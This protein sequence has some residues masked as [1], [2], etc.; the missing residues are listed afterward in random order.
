MARQGGGRP[1]RR[2]GRT[3][4]ALERRAGSTSSHSTPPRIRV[5]RKPGAFLGSTR[6]Y[7]GPRPSAAGRFARSTTTL[8]QAY[9]RRRSS[10]T[11]V[12][13]SRRSGCGWVRATAVAYSRPKR[14]TRCL[15]R[16]ISGR[17]RFVSKAAQMRLRW[18][19][20]SLRWRNAEVSHPM[21]FE[22]ALRLIR[23]ACLQAKAVFREVFERASTS[24]VTLLPG[25]RRT[26]LA[27]V[28]STFQAVLTLTEAR[29]QFKRSRTRLPRASST[30]VDSPT[31]E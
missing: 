13:V 12:A 5:P 6:T 8:G 29:A 16:L 30:S 10:R 9:A 17:H 1:K 7:A 3:V 19:P 27:F 15:H 24:F 21:R 11:S 31:Q 2:I 28:L 4:C 18:R 14:S 23:S 20:V 26:R 25:V 22:A